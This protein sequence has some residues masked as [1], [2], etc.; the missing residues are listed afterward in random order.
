MRPSSASSVAASGRETFT[1]HPADE[2]FQGGPLAE[3]DAVE[4]PSVLTQ[5]VQP[6]GADLDHEAVRANGPH[7]IRVLDA[8]P[9]EQDAR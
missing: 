2:P 3:G 4:D 7:P 9:T 6:L 8:T 1:L 5:L